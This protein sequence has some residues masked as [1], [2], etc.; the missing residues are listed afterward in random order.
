M[1]WIIHLPYPIADENTLA[2]VPAERCRDGKACKA[3]PSAIAAFNRLCEAAK[4]AG[5]LIVVL[6]SYRTVEDQKKLFENAEKRYGPGKGMLWVAPSGYSEHHTGY[7]FDLGDKTQP[8][9]DDEP[10]FET[11][12]AAQW[13][14]NN[15]HRF[16][17][18][19]SFPK[20]NWQGVGYEPWHWRYVGDDFSKRLFH[21]RFL[22]NIVRLWTAKRILL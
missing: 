22:K 2:L 1:K 9:T 16:S 6:S 8:Q 4:K 3:N 15:A 11:T 12:L 13:L 14:K 10:I 7:V 18:E 21:P 5:V 19:L 20:G 17:F